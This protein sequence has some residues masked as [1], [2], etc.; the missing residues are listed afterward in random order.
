MCSASEAFARGAGGDDA[1]FSGTGLSHGDE[2]QELG[3]AE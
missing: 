1:N 3:G 2:Q